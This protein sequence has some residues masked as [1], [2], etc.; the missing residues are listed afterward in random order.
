MCSPM[1][2]YFGLR[3]FISHVKADKLSL[4]VSFAKEQ[5]VDLAIFKKH[6]YH[7][8]VIFSKFWRAQVSRNNVQPKGEDV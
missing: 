8:N 5:F 2:T 1:H 4:K 6:L 3:D 7:Q